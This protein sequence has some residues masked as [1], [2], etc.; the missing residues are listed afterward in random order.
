MPIRGAGTLAAEYQFVLICLNKRAVILIA[1]HWNA[2]SVIQEYK[3]FALE[4]RKIG[5]YQ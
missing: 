4:K 3:R 2:I 5:S 1:N